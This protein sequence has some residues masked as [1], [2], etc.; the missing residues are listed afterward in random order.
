MR[1]RNFVSS[2]SLG[3]ALPIFGLTEAARF[4]INRRA[5]KLFNF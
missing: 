1:V 5:M 2:W 4:A 3:I